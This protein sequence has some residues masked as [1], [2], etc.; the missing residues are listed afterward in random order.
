M[1]I[2]SLCR[3][4]KN[5]KIVEGSVTNLDQIISVYQSVRQNVSFELV[6]GESVKGFRRRG[7]DGKQ[8]L[9][10]LNLGIRQTSDRMQLQHKH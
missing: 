6:F 2:L 9:A 1:D 8:R 3:M 4:A 5:Y 7:S 10:F